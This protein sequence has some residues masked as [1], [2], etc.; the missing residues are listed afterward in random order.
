MWQQQELSPRLRIMMKTERFII[1]WTSVI[2]NGVVKNIKHISS[3]NM[4]MAREVKGCSNEVLKKIIKKSDF[5]NTL[6]LS[7]PRMW[8]NNVTEGYD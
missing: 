6:I 5:E 1:F 7:P 2:E 3:M 4:R 8:K